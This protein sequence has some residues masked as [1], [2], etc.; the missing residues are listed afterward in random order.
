MRSARVD[1]VV[2]HLHAQADPVLGAQRLDELEGF[3]RALAAVRELHEHGQSEGAGRHATGFHLLQDSHAAIPQPVARAAVDQRVVRD[4]VGAEV[5]GLLHVL[6]Q[7]EG[8]VQTILLAIAFDDG[9]VRDHVGLDALRGHLLE[10]RGDAAHVA[11]PGTRVDQRVVGDDGELQPLCLH[12]FIHRPHPVEALAVRKAFQYRTI[13]DCIDHGSNRGILQLLAD[14]L[15]AS[16]DVTIRR[17]RLDHATDGHARRNDVAL[18]HLAP[19][20]PNFVHFVERTISTDHA[21]VSVRAFDVQIFVRPL[22]LQVL[23]EEVRTARANASFAHRAHQYLVHRFLHLVDDQEGL[24]DVGSPRRFADAFKHDRASHLVRLASASFHLVDQSPDAI[25]AVADGPIDQLV[26]SDRIWLQASRP[27][28]RNG[29]PRARH[30]AFPQ[31]RLD[32]RVVSNDVGE[33][34]I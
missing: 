9:A 8:P 19:R 12:L 34:G 25:G 3:V 15:V 20:I 7:L 11:T 21:A 24:L 5:L 17:E 1:E 14:E 2:E 30:V 28:R 27:H 23:A 22:P 13:N 18:P 32:H 31:V 6:Q 29:C 16:V 10:Q 33:F 4:L 26:E